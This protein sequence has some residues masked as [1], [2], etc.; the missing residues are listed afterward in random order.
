[1][2]RWATYSLDRLHEVL[3]PSKTQYMIYIIQY[4]ASLTFSS[5]NTQTFYLPVTIVQMY[6][7]GD[8]AN[9]INRADLINHSRHRRLRVGPT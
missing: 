8:L 7:P 4:S 3:Q 6:G 2:F 9:L 1:M 5:P